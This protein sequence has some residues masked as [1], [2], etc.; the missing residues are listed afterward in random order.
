MPHPLTSY[1]L[2]TPLEGYST[3]L[4]RGWGGPPPQGP[5]PYRSV[6]KSKWRAV[7]SINVS[8][9]YKLDWRRSSKI[10]AYNQKCSPSGQ[11]VFWYFAKQTKSKTKLERFCMLTWLGRASFTRVP[12]R[13][14]NGCTASQ[15]CAHYALKLVMTHAIPN[16]CVA[17]TQSV[18]FHKRKKFK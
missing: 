5:S 1:T 17:W 4:Y 10:I 14:S 15:S 3:E 8:A 7:S 2:S 9:K 11:S 12:P 6:T 13:F 16:F 18:I